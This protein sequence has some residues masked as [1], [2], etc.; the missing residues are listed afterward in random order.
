ME[1]QIFQDKKEDPFDARTHLHNLEF[2]VDYGVQPPLFMSEFGPHQA[3]VV[4]VVMLC[5][6]SISIIFF[7]FK[8]LLVFIDYFPFWFL[9]GDLWY[10]AQ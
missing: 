3:F 6:R 1:W 4:F 8:F 7:D 5:T 10:L 2:S 9:I